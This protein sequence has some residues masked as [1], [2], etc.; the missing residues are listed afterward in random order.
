MRSDSFISMGLLF[1]REL[2]N[3]HRSLTGNPTHIT[4]IAVD[5]MANG[6]GF[7]V[8]APSIFFHPQIN[9]T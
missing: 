1:K 2:R 5:H 9:N 7:S 4:A 3:L 6:R 8:H